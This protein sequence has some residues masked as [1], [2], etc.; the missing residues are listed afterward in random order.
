MYSTCHGFAPALLVSG[1]LRAS[2]S[3]KAVHGRFQVHT[4]SNPPI[5]IMG[6]IPALQL[7]LHICTGVCLCRFPQRVQFSGYQIGSCIIPLITRS[8]CSII[9]APIYLEYWIWLFY[10]SLKSS[11]L[12]PRLNVKAMSSTVHNMSAMHYTCQL[13]SNQGDLLMVG[14]PLPTQIFSPF[15]I[16]ALVLHRPCTVE[17]GD[18][19]HPPEQFFF[20]LQVVFWTNTMIPRALRE[21]A[22][23]QH[24]SI[25]LRQHYCFGK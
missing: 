16:Q 3:L 9:E 20:V 14:R 4:Y 24:Q 22:A 18:E 11:M 10:V 15:Q 21:A 12:N 25:Y 13:G 5:I 1:L 8:F 2:W 6:H 23:F 19:A 17:T 7:Y